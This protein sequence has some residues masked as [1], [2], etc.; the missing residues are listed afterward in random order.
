MLVW[1]SLALL[2]A[3]L[4]IV[5]Q[6]GGGAA[7]F[8]FGVILLSAGLVAIGSGWRKP[9]GAAVDAPW[10]APDDRPIGRD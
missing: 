6:S 2:G 7:A 10:P 5:G 3:V 8:W 1:I 4:A 9:A